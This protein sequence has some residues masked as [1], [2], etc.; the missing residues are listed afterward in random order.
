[1]IACIE[2]GGGQLAMA[3]NFNLHPLILIPI[4]CFV[5]NFL[6]KDLLKLMTYLMLPYVK[7]WFLKLLNNIEHFY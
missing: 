7:V 5:P 6:S 2:G 3:R 1:M 4:I